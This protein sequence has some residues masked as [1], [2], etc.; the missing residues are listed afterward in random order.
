[1]SRL[2]HPLQHQRAQPDGRPQDTL[3]LVRLRRSTNCRCQRPPHHPCPLQLRLINST[4]P[5]ASTIDVIEDTIQHAPDAVAAYLHG[6]VLKYVVQHVHKTNA[7]LDAQPAYLMRL[8]DHLAAETHES[9]DETLVIGGG[10][11]G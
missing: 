3:L 5:C 4:T 2:R 9:Q 6:Q 10:H 1:M 11:A 8:C 7:E